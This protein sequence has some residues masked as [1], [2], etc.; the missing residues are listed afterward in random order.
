MIGLGVGIG[1]NRYGG[2]SGLLNEF[3]DGAA[4]YSLRRLSGSANKAIQVRRESDNGTLDIGFKSGELDTATLETFVKAQDVSAADYG[5]GAAAAYSLRKVSASYTGSAIQVRVNTTGQP[6]YDIGFVDGELDVATLESRCAGGLNAFVTT[7][8]DQSGNGNH[9]TQATSE[10]QPQIVSGGVVIIDSGKPALD[11][12]GYDDVMDLPDIPVSL[13]SLYFAIRPKN[14]FLPRERNGGIVSLTNEPVLN[15]HFTGVN[16]FNDDWYDSFYSTERVLLADNSV[17]KVSYI[18]VLKRTNSQLSARLNNVDINSVSVG[19]DTDVSI[20]YIGSDPS[21][22]FPSSHRYQELI[23]YP[24]DQGTDGRNIETNMNQYYNYYTNDANG[25]VTTWYDQ[26]GNGNDATQSTVSNQPQIVSSGSI[27]L[28]NEKPAIDFTNSF[29]IGD[30]T[31]MDTGE[32]MVVHSVF[33]PTLASAPNVTSAHIFTYAGGGAGVNGHQYGAQTGV[34][35]NDTLTIY[36]TSDEVIGG[37]LASSTYSHNASEQLLHSIYFTQG[38]TSAYKNNNEINFD[39]LAGGGFSS[40]TSTA[41]IDTNVSSNSFFINSID[42]SSSVNPIKH[43][44]VIFYSSD[45]SSNRSGIE[46]NINAQYQIY[47]DGSQTTLLDSYSGSAAAYSLRALNS[48]YTGPLV[49]V[50]RATGGE[51]DIYAKYDGTLNINDLESFCS[52]TDGFVATWYDQSGNGNHATQTNA[53]NQPRIVSSGSVILENGK[54]ALSFDGSNDT[55]FTLYQTSG[56]L[57]VFYISK[58][59]DNTQDR[60]VVSSFIDGNNRHF[61]F[62]YDVG[63]NLYRN[64]VFDTS[65]SNRLD[66]SSYDSNQNLISHIA[67]STSQEFIKNNT[68]STSTYTLT[69]LGV[70]TSY[71]QIASQNASDKFFAGIIQELIFYPSDQSSNRTGIETNIND[72]YNIY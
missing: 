31:D 58:I 2:F 4:A 29:L 7:W 35:N 60:T 3:G 67:T 50:R 6:T 23:L 71:L 24:T 40:S 70:G 5:D 45:Q 54:P 44:E 48:S 41:P 61:L 66:V 33:V 27:I 8:Y 10:S 34:F 62:W 37:R 16:S 43:Q 57:S 28:E 53:N 30:I 12:D 13:P 11:F 15:N 72:F 17:P 51:K 25:F 69:G 47:W 42:G 14:I 39:L 56:D 59:T 38:G 20:R 63:D 49:R 68:V 22:G 19:L 52:G 9:A 21:N 26:S 18:G 65:A 36:Y 1:R 55:F 32:A 64:D 46:R